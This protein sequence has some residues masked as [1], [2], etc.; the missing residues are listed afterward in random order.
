[1]ILLLVIVQFVLWAHASQ[2][3]RLAASE[4]DETARAW[5]STPAA[6]VTRAQSVL[7]GRSADVLSPEAIATMLPGDQVEITVHG[8][9][10]S[11]VP[12]LSFPVTST[13]VGPLQE[14]RPSE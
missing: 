5:Q 4:G 6:G 8:R 13:A 11:V 10:Q 3:V 1:M 9:A 2:A 7:S 14:F 12:G